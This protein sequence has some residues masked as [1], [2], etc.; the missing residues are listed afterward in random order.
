MSDVFIHALVYKNKA[1]EMSNTLN[2]LLEGI[3]LSKL[4][5]VSLL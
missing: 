3:F 4:R 2:Q 1:L 5:I